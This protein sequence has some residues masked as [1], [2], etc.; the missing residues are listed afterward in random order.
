MVFV[1][2][3]GWF[4]QNVSAQIPQV[5]RLAARGYAAAVVEYRHSGIAPFPAQIMDARNVVRF[6]RTH[7]AEYHVVFLLSNL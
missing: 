7:A 2:G 3:S 6:M 5:S 1:Q 4:R